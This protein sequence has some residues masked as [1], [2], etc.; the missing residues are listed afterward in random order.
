MPAIAEPPQQT[1]TVEALRNGAVDL[2][3]FENPFL[4]SMEGGSPPSAESLPPGG[5]APT[6]S[7]EIDAGEELEPQAK[8]EPPAEQELDRANDPFDLDAAFGT[9]EEKKKANKGLRE[10]NKELRE[11][12]RDREAAIEERE[13]R[14]KELQAQQEE[15]SREHGEYQRALSSKYEIGEYDPGRDP[16]VN[17][18]TQDLIAKVR[19]AHVNL[20]DEAGS[21]L[22][23]HWEK[24]LSGYQDAVAGKNTKEFMKLIDD[25][26]DEMA[27]QVRRELGELNT[28]MQKQSQTIATNRSKYFETVIGG[29]DQK[30]NEAKQLVSTIGAMPKEEMKDAND[31]NTIITF[32]VG[33]D[34]TY[35]EEVEKVKRTAVALASGV[36]PFDIRDA[37]WRS[38][39]DPEE[40]TRLTQE[41]ERLRQKEAYQ[42]E[43]AQKQLPKK[44]AEVWAAALLV[45]RLVKKLSEMSA[46]LGDDQGSEI[47]PKIGSEDALKPKEGSAITEA[48]LDDPDMLK[49][50]YLPKL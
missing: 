21:K 6:L 23:Q 48:D 29:Y 31:L 1:N 36:R 17:Q 5:E 45:P 25:N 14:L 2:D 38:Y 50:P 32:A 12:L 15:L 24:L 4:T 30:V 18:L 7:E 44:L 8:Q 13:N 47:D 41:G 43:A 9:R 39:V 40:P 11:Q 20:G 19:T 22:A 28:L 35:R 34:P 37:K 3:S 49:N 42:Y 33:G 10:Q 46:R 27:P 26:F 16:E